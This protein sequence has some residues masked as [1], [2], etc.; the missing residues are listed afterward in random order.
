MKTWNPLTEPNL[1]ADAT[2]IYDDLDPFIEI[3]NMDVVIVEK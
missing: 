1:I 3:S 2:E